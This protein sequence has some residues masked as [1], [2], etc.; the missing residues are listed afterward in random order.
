M[1]GAIKGEG[2]PLIMAGPCSAESLDQLLKAA[3]S[4]R[5]MPLHL[6]RAGVWKPR[7]RPNAFEGSGEL[8]L[9]W[10]SEVRDQFGYPIA[11]EVAS[12]AHAELALKYGVD[13]VWIGARTTVNPFYVQ[14]IAAALAGRD[15]PVIIKNPVHA[16]LS[17]WRGAIERF[18][19]LGFTNI[20]ALHRGFYNGDHKVYRNLPIWQIP[21]ELKRLYPDLQIICDIS[22]I[23]GRTDNLLETAQMALDLRY[24]G[25]MVEVHPNPP[26]ALSDPDQQVTGEE[27]KHLLRQLIVRD[28][29]DANGLTSQSLFDLRKRIDDIDGDIISLLQARM[30]LAME[31]G[32]VKKEFKIP[33][34]QPERWA[35]VLMK[36]QKLAESNG[37]SRDF[38]DQVYAAVHQESILSQNK[39]MNIQNK[40]SDTTSGSGVAE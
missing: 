15:I 26:K 11:T 17:L 40:G 29:K 31:I 10:L 25:L 1:E 16:D 3:S 14:D 36:V 32:A 2:R 34:Y 28:L 24:D 7:T 13:A 21:L 20:S 8:G 38:I 22:H 23:C 9:Q 18:L 30:R 39:V 35:Q 6:F 37:M 33:I 27:L 19:T 12:P 4:M 5:D